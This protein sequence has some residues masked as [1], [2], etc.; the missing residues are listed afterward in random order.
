MKIPQHMDMDYNNEPAEI[1]D[2][3]YS[4][5]TSSTSFRNNKSSPPTTSTT[6]NKSSKLNMSSNTLQNSSTNIPTST[7]SSSSNSRSHSPFSGNQ[8]TSSSNNNPEITTI[9][10]QMIEHLEKLVGQIDQCSP[11]A[12][13]SVWIELLN[14]SIDT[15]FKDEK[16]KSIQQSFLFDSNCTSKFKSYYQS[17]LKNNIINYHSIE[18]LYNA[19]MEAE[20]KNPNLFKHFSPQVN[21]DPHKDDSANQQNVVSNL[22][23]SS[24][25]W[26]FS[27]PA[28]LQQLALLIYWTPQLEKL[29][30][31]QKKMIW[32]TA[33]ALPFFQQ[34]Y[35]QKSQ[36]KTPN[37]SK[38]IKS[39][40][41]N[42]IQHLNLI[43]TLFSSIGYLIDINFLKNEFCY[44]QSNVKVFGQS[45]F[46]NNQ[47]HTTTTTTTTT[48]LNSSTNSLTSSSAH[49]NRSGSHF[50]MNDGDDSG[51]E[52]IE[53]SNIRV[54][55]KQKRSGSYNNYDVPS[56]SPIQSPTRCISNISSSNSSPIFVSPVSIHDEFDSQKD[57]DTDIETQTIDDNIVNNS[58]VP[59]STTNTN[60]NNENNNE[61]SDSNLINNIPPVP[62]SKRLGKK[63]RF[64]CGEVKT[65]QMCIMSINNILCS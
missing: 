29:P 5:P 4:V 25:L 10:S 37:F 63:R 27:F 34:H 51:V 32:Q 64:S 24:T 60:T 59:S 41:Q 31:N 18:L 26:G 52:D 6:N 36:T 19:F 49:I 57:D 33:L 56:L 23:F 65:D 8:N 7:S 46:V 43:T 15:T 13:Q 48:T 3:F 38:I 16:P 11:A 17:L 61:N 58:E 42:P 12:R 20:K 14:Q 55:K 44:P 9:Y 47:Q 35:Q 21:S 1:I 50:E 62:L 2:E 30:K 53:E 54:Y 39:W 22:F 45:Q 40:I 28:S